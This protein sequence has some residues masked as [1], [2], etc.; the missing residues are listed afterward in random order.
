M[1][2]MCFDKYTKC[3][4]IWLVILLDRVGEGG[5]WLNYDCNLRVTKD[6]FRKICWRIVYILA[7]WINSFP[8][9][10][11]TWGKSVET[12]FVWLYW[13]TLINYK[14]LG[15]IFAIFSTLYNYRLFKLI[16][17]NWLNTLRATMNIHQFLYLEHF[18]H[19]LK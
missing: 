1:F 7:L 12:K 3:L 14:K 2:E 17:I 5:K 16:L 4:E 9:M 8:K 13:T 6:I 10:Q 11:N 19:R 15:L 18:L